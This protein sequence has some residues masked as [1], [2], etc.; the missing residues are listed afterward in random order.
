MDISSLSNSSFSRPV[1]SSRSSSDRQFNEQTQAA[2]VDNKLQERREHE[3]AIQEKLQHRREQNQRRL[4]GR[5][6][7]FGSQ[8]QDDVSI[9]QKQ[10]SYNRS[11][12]NDAY[13]TSSNE[14]NRSNRYH[15]QR[16]QRQNIDAIDIV[17]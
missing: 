5:I 6:I 14:T 7:S 1:T 16:S 9:Q 10:A 2:L 8:Q 11:R 4:D 15:E 13:G 17:V 12:V 3:R